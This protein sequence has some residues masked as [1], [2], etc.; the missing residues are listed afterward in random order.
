MADNGGYRVGDVANGHVLTEQGWLR[1]HDGAATQ[2]AYP[3]GP[4][5]RSRTGLW[6][7]LVVATIVIV[8]V[9]GGVVLSL[10]YARRPG[11]TSAPEVTTTTTPGSA[12]TTVEPTPSATTTDLAEPSTPASEGQRFAYSETASLSFHGV[13][14]AEITVA[15]PVEFAPIDAGDSSARGRLVY[16]PVLLQVVGQEKVAIDPFD[17]EVVLPDGAH[18]DVAYV[19]QLPKQSPAQ[20]SAAD[21]D[22][23]GTVVGSIPFDVPAGVPLKIAYAPSGQVLGTWQ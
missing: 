19:K 22:P 21:V 16:V 13:R 20:L 2:P 4:G 6:V 5:P 15:K 12:T 14:S 10:A 18:L 7:T 17:F 9:V 23:G 1:L 3:S 8:G 11:G